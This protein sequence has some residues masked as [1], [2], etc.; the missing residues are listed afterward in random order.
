[1][2]SKIRKFLDQP[3]ESAN[4]PKPNMDRYKKTSQD[5]QIEITGRGLENE[6]L[7]VQ[8]FTVI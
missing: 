8:N 1:M 4:T 7:T 5:L 3:S 6:T 2:S